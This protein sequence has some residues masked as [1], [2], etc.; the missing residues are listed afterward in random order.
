MLKAIF[1]TW[2]HKKTR[3]SRLLKMKSYRS[4]NLIKNNNILLIFQL[5]YHFSLS[6][7]F[8]SFL[9]ELDFSLFFFGSPNSLS[10]PLWS[11]S[12]SLSH[13]GSKM[14][15]VSS[16][17]FRD[18]S[19]LILS[20]FLSTKSFISPDLPFHRGYVIC[21]VGLWFVVF[22]GCGFR[23]LWWRFWV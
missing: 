22:V 21:E 15:I 5:K 8:L 7:Y 16:F 14:G 2:N 13:F 10:V 19:R 1:C 23:R 12:P 4:S 17:W 9:L 18:G 3:Y 11:L 20:L 6:H